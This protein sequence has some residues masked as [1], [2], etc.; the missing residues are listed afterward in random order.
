MSWNNTFHELN[1]SGKPIGE[2]TMATGIMKDVQDFYALWLNNNPLLEAKTSG[3][4]G[5]PKTILLKKESMVASAKQTNDFFTL[6]ETSNLLLNLP[7]GFIAGKMMIVRAIVSG[8]NLIVTEPKVNPLL[9][10]ETTSS[11]DF[12]A[13]TPQQVA[14]I[15]SD[16]ISLE[17]FQSIPKI[18]IGGGEIPEQ[19]EKKLNGF[20]NEIY[21]TYGMTETITHVAVRK[22]SQGNQAKI[23]NVFKGIRLGQDERG[24]LTIQANYLGNEPIVTNDLVEFQGPHEF[25]WLGRI[26]NV[27]NSGG[28][29]LFPEKIE[30]KIRDFFDR[31]F[32]L[33]GRPHEALGQTLEMVI[34]GEPLDEATLKLLQN[35][36]ENELEKYE[37]PK[38]ISFLNQFERTESG[39]V[40]RK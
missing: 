35:M 10:L 38:K 4:T 34:E 15:L 5:E 32:Y 22:V 12:A 8:A 26:D 16:K 18:I 39:K 29:K 7:V 31:T 23:Y 30:T 9:S 13:F 24:C 2:I 28:I 3:S 14:A 40:K 37:K 21:A 27:V 17:R 33:I 36:L 6:N 20:G 19:L 1:V 25:E 11:I